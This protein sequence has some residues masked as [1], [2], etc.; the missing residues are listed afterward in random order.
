MEAQGVGADPALVECLVEAAMRTAELVLQVQCRHRGDRAGRAD[1]GV[2]QLEKGVTPAAQTLTQTETE[3]HQRSAAPCV[4]IVLVV[5][6]NS[7][8][9]H[10]R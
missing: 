3:P 10:F 9:S 8:I 6:G 4:G 5:I 1:G 7:R 2:S